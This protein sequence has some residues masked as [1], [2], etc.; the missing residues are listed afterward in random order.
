MTDLRDRLADFEA[1][2]RRLL[3]QPTRPCR[4]R[5]GTARNRRAA[6]C[7]PDRPVE[8]RGLCRPCYSKAWSEGTLAAHPRKHRSRRSVEEFADLWQLLSPEGATLQTIA[9]RLG[10][11]RRAALQAHRRAIRRG[12]IEPDRRST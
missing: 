5:S 11:T 1:A 2:A 12:L 4:C 8:A 3:D 6:T 9:D 10:M 7:H